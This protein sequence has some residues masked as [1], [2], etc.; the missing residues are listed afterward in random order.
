MQDLKNLLSQRAA[1]PNKS[2]MRLGTAVIRLVVQ[3]LLITSVAIGPTLSSA[4]EA[5]KLP[6]IGWCAPVDSATDVPYQTAFR[7]GLRDLGYVDGENVRLIVR[8]AN[9]DRT[10][11]R[12]NI[13]ELIAL[14]VDILM[15]DAPAGVEA[16]KTIPMVSL[17]MSDPVKT[18]LV[19]S[20][21]RPG[22][23]L[24]GLS[25][26]SY[27]IWPKQLE[28][29][30][31]LVP[32]LKRVSFL[33]D[34][35]E[36]PHALTYA[37]EF[38]ELARGTGITVRTLPIAS[39]EDLRGALK[40]VR[41][42]RPQVLIVWTSPLMVQ[43]RRTIIDSVAHRLP[44]ISDARLLGENGAVLT[45]SVD[46]LDMFRRGAPY[47]DKILKGAKPGDLPVEQ[48]NKFKLILN[49]RTAKALG[50]KVPESILARAD[51]IIR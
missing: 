25:A 32:N 41:K 37:H 23:N 50:I 43:H 46:W 31:E 36:E 48:P 16:T 17:T 8:Y 29:A 38:S 9:G 42:E 26:Q 20:L 19:A 15:T 40:T 13:R 14:P 4:D 2:R 1:L 45:Y 6:T 28:L 49:L 35:S 18:G 10:K 51:E 22:G 34:T 30:R 39:L 24:T 44:V 33:F 21:A 11:F 5:R 47:I 27:D 7:N 3:G 12:A